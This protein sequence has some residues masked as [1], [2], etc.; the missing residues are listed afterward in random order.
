MNKYLLL[1]CLFVANSLTAQNFIDTKGELAVSGSGTPSYKVPIAL[2]PG[3][4]DVAPQ[5]ALVYSGASVQGMAGMG[6]NLVGVSSISRVSS[7]LDIDNTMDAVDFDA[8]DRF[9]LDGQRLIEKV[10][11]YGAAGT[12]YQT[13]NYSNLK[14]ES[15]GSFA[16]TGLT[17]PIGP[18]TFTVTFPD[19]IQA[20]YGGTTDS[21][22]ISEW[23]INRWID[24]QG[25]YINY[26][27]ETENN[28]IRIKD[29]TWGKN[30]NVTSTFENKITFTYKA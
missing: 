6:W 23:M 30:A 28:A 29:I 25:N 2:P 3:I 12:T 22:G 21:R 26:T 9:A 1:I 16:Y 4:K 18:Q 7:R 24:P 27:Y 15:T 14:I 10:G 20:I 13:E 17:N 8:L 19:G 11:V 5:L